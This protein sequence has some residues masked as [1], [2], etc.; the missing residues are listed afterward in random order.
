MT[1]NNIGKHVSRMVPS[2]YFLNGLLFLLSFKYFHSMSNAA[3]GR[4]FSIFPITW[5]LASFNFLRFLIYKHHTI[6]E[7]M[8]AEISARVFASQIKEI[9]AMIPEF[10]ET[11]KL[12]T[13]SLRSLMALAISTQVCHC[14]RSISLFSWHKITILLLLSLL[15]LSIF[16]VV[17]DVEGKG[18]TCI[19]RFLSG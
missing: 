3:I 2:R 7:R 10:R 15:L 19:I 8:P 11:N 5:N 13:E 18:V 1:E 12:L 14:D 9:A 4:Y 17:R 6:Q 16:I